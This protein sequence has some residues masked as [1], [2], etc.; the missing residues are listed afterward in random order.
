MSGLRLFTPGTGRRNV[1]WS[2]LGGLLA[3][4]L[5]AGL[6]EAFLRN[7]PPRDL[8]PYLGESSPLTGPFAPDDDFGAGYRSW[9]TFRADYSERLDQLG[10]LDDARPTWAMFG[11]S[12]VQAP[13]M[14]AD[15]ARDRLTDHRI[16]NLG[17]NEHLI[18][19]LA[20][21]RLLLERGF[22][23]ERIILLLLPLD[24]AMLGEQPLATV[25]VTARGALTYQPRLPAGPGALA[26]SH[27]RLALTG[28]V[29]SG[30]Q[31]GNPGFRAAQLN[32][33]IAGPLL[34]D[35]D[36]VF[37]N[38]ARI[39]RDHG[40]PVTVILL[41]NHEQVMRGVP[42]GFQDALGPVLCRHGYDVLDTREVFAGQPDRAALF[43]PDKHLTPRGNALLLDT[44]LDHLRAADGH[45]AAATARGES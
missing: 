16:F 5:L 10:P 18:I 40:V 12:F 19:R 36:T 32:Q 8:H 39:T 23:P 43:L 44:L 29:R 13:G 28:W 41:P 21:I 33:G 9:D 1:A 45:A 25:H 4:A 37:G 2:V 24:V 38:L 6:A 42:C 3:A 20:Q 26:I 34:A 27:S 11:N 7:F 35:L 14:L 31:H 17:R 30:R 22:R 15:T